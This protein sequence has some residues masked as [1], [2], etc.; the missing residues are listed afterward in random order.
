MGFDFFLK[1]EAAEDGGE[2]GDEDVPQ[3][4]EAGGVFAEEA[5]EEAA[6]ALKVEAEDGED[7]ADLDDDGE[8]FGAVGGGDAE[9]FL[10]EEDVA[11]G[12]DGEVFGEAFDEAD[13]DGL[14]PVHEDV[15]G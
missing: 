15:V 9:D 12:A 6:A 5:E 2:E 13:E 8:G 1:E 3:E 7:G 10:G 11:G 14:P 4:E